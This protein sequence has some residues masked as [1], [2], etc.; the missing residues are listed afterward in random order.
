MFQHF[1]TL[2]I[3]SSLFGRKEISHPVARHGQRVALARLC[4]PSPENTTDVTVSQDQVKCYTFLLF[5]VKFDIF[6]F[7]PILRNYEMIHSCTFGMF[8]WL[9]ASNWYE[10]TI[11]IFEGWD[12]V[13]RCFIDEF[14]GAVWENR[15]DPNWKHRLWFLSFRFI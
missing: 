12:A 9:H 11:G 2:G 3:L 6:P 14:Q 4:H 10:N 7:H 5:W 1:S 13:A 15:S 8:K